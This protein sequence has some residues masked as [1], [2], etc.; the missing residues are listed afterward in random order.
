MVSLWLLPLIGNKYVRMQVEWCHLIWFHL[1]WWPSA[2]YWWHTEFLQEKRRRTVKSPKKMKGDLVGH[3]R[4]LS[5]ST[6]CGEAAGKVAYSIEYIKAWWPANGVTSYNTPGLPGPFV[7]AHKQILTEQVVR[8]VAR[9]FSE[10]TFL[11]ELLTG[12]LTEGIFIEMA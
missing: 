5:W 6:C 2:V 3:S 8:V 4:S 7:G 9:H 10:I 1:I 12:I 11:A